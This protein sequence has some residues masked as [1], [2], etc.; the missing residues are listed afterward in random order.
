MLRVWLAR[1]RQ[2]LSPNKAQT[3]FIRS[4]HVMMDGQPIKKR[5]DMAV[6]KASKAS[7]KV[8]KGLF[9]HLRLNP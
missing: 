2:K 3:G 8:F 9:V 6:L 4:K 7:V 5:K 1:L